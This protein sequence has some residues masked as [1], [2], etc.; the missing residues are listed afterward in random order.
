MALYNHIMSTKNPAEI[1]DLVNFGIT[2]TKTNISTSDLM[3]LTTAT[4]KNPPTSFE[5]LSLPFS[6]AYRGGYY[7]GMSILFFD[8][9]STSSRL[10]SILYN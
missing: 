1:Y 4:I 2:I 3:S 5:S 10:R 6:D 9:P 7:N 8:L